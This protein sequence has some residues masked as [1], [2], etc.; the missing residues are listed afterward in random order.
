MLQ[1]TFTT[2]ILEEKPFKRER[3]SGEMYYKIVM[4][5]LDQ[6]YGY[7][8]GNALRR[9]LLNS[10]EGAAITRVRIK[11]IHHQFTTLEGMREDI[12]E[13]ILN[14]KQVRLALV[15]PEAVT[16]KLSAHGPG[17]VTAKDITT[18]AGVKIVN[19]DLVLAVLAD[20]AATLEAELDVEVGRGY[21]VAQTASSSTLGEI[22]VDALFSPVMKV[23][24]K[25]EATR[26]GRRTD[27]DRLIL[28]IYTDGSMD[29]MVALKRAAEVLVDHFHQVYEPTDTV[30]EEP[31]ALI[32]KTDE[33]YNLT[34]EEL[35]IPTRI[36]NALRKG[37]Y[38]TVGDLIEALKEDV[39]KVKNLGEKSV[40]LV[41]K[42][43]E[44]KG[45]QFKE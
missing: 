23:S 21:Q 13:F 22:P 34:V 6:G 41:A 36:A 19:P 12:V 27:F 20:R 4:E 38:K 33:T 32:P 26:V 37:G 29:G 40:S 31:V 30:K 14:V 28:E 17:Q 2:T 8:L 24:Y 10:I 35:D 5:P 16:L 1:P 3:G 18:P 11:G 42:A 15:Q 44:K 45:V 7:T 43:L 25:V 39:A 9:V